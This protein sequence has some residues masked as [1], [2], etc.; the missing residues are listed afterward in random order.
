MKLT[1]KILSISLQG[2][3]DAKKSSG[4]ISTHLAT[5]STAQKLVRQ[6]SG[7]DG[8]LFR[9]QS[10]SAIM[11]KGDDDRNDEDTRDKNGGTGD[12]NEVRSFSFVWLLCRVL[13]IVGV[14]VGTVDVRDL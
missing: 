1:V 2:V 14:E 13:L 7:S 5:T 3:A 9:R 10:S 11:R 6:K 12:E 4:S 8:I